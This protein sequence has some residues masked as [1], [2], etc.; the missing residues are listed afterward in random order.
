[1]VA[2]I[3]VPGSSTRICSAEHT[4]RSEITATGN[5]CDWHFQG[6]SF[7]VETK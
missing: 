5:H 7:I 4:L 1:M 6:A 2:K 3:M